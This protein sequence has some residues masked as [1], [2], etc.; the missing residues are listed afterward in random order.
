MSA[1][2][3]HPPLIVHIVHRFDTGGM[4]NGMVNLFNALPA[5]SFRHAVICLTDYSAF[6][7]RIT[8]Q[9]V[10]FYALHKSP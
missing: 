6:R 5:A 1:G 4:E 8:A 9:T 10:G 7:E 2:G 3:I